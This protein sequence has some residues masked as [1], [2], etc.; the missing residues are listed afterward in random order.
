MIHHR[1]HPVAEYQAIVDENTQ[2]IDVRR[3][4]EVAEGSLDGAINI[5]LDQLSGRVKELDPT[6]T[7]VLLCRS[8]NRSTQAAEFLTKAGFTDVVN[9]DGGMLAH[10]QEK[11]A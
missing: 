6:R 5:P 7:T 10:S 9:L 4:E 11:S 1:N 3:P 8:G 2:L